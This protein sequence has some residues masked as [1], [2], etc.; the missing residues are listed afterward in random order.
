MNWKKACGIN[1]HLMPIYIYFISCKPCIETAILYKA[2]FYNTYI[3]KIVCARLAELKGRGRSFCN[4][5][6]QYKKVKSYCTRRDIR[7]Q[8]SYSIT[9]QACINRSILFCFN[10]IFQSWSPVLFIVK[11]AALS[12]VR[13]STT[14]AASA[15]PST[16]TS[17]PARQTSYS[18]TG[19]ACI[20]RQ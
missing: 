20:N 7:R 12:S 14:Q 1:F 8:T 13:L 5:H 2:V 18:I 16:Y 3:I 4:K 19:Q 9:G 11:S 6:R 10:C 17:Y 15:L